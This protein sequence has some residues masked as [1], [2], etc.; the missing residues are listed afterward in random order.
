MKGFQEVSKSF[1][2]RFFGTRSARSTFP[3][4]RLF[5][6]STDLATKMMREAARVARNTMLKSSPDSLF[7]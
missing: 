5:L 1:P 6:E 7:S 2:R 3:R 4:F